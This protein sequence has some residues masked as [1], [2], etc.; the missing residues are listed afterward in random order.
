MSWNTP[1]EV[2]GRLSAY[3]VEYESITPGIEHHVTTTV[4]YYRRYITLTRLQEHT[5]Y[6]VAVRVRNGA[7][8]SE[9]ARQTAKTLEA[10][11]CHVRLLSHSV[12][13]SYA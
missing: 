9:D 4:P 1:E 13:R 3:I 11:K 7:G 6:S 5:T 8:E 10:G 2:N 12:I